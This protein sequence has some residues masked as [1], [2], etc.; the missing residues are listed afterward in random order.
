MNYTI[1]DTYLPD[2]QIVHGVKHGDD[3]GWFNEVFNVEAF[4]ELG[5]PTNFVQMNHSA[6]AK[7]TVR[8]LHFQWEPPMGKLMRI[9]K[10]KAFLV[11]VDIRIDSP[12]FGMWYSGM[13]EEGDCKQLWAPAGFARG[14]M[15]MTEGAEVQYLITGTYNPANESE[16]KWDDSD[17]AIDWP[18][19]IKV[20]VSDK[21]KNAQSFK[22]WMA[23]E[24][25]RN[26]KI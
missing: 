25:S 11:A 18:E 4:K 21:D 7:G 13:F 12:T 23:S 19:D 5:L 8:G 22:E 10:G 2:V 1:E 16:I 24:Y 20:I 9:T 26:F 6:S 15:A 14:F 17:L 3:R